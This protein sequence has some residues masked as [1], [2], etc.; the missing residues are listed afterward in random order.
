MEIK[1]QIF[2]DGV[3]QRHRSLKALQPDYV[4][5]DERTLADGL[6]FA[7]VYAKQLRYFNL[8][9]QADGDWF[10]FFAGDIQQMLDYLDHPE[11][12][13]PKDASQLS[14]FSQPH[15]ALF[16]T[17][18]KL[19][20][21]PQQQFKDLTQRY[22]D[23]YYRDVLR[24]TEKAATPD[25]VHVVFGLG[26]GE[27]THLIRQGTR[28]SA[29]PDS[30][31]V[32]Q[33]Y[34]LN[35]DIYLNQAQVASV[36]TLAVEKAYID[37]KAIH[38]K[39]NRS[40]DAF[41]NVLRWA[42]GTPNQGDALPNY[43]AGEPDDIP[44]Y[45]AHINTLYLDNVKDLSLEEIETEPR[46]YILNQLCFASIENFQ[47]CLH[48]HNREISVD[49]E[50]VPPTDS[51]WEQVYALIEKAYR[52]KIT[53][54]RRLVLSA[55]HRNPQYTSPDVAFEAML[56]LALGYPDPGDSLPPLPDGSPVT[57]NT[58]NTLF[59]VFNPPDPA[60]SVVQNASQYVQEQLYMSVDDFQTIME[61]KQQLATD[62]GTPDYWT[63]QG[64]DN[65]YRL[66]EKAQSKLRG[67]TYPPIGRMEIQAISAAGIANAE[68]GEIASLKRFNTFSPNLPDPDLP[69]TVPQPI[70]LAITSPV[71]LL[72]EG[73]RDVT[74]SLTFKGETFN[75]DLLSKLVEGRD[76]PFELA[77]S[78]EKEWLSITGD[79]LTVQVGEF[80][81]EEPLREF[82]R[83]ALQPFYSAPE[84]LLDDLSNISGEPPYFHFQDASV[85][86]L[87]EMREADRT[88]KLT[89]VGQ[90]APTDRIA[91]Y[92]SLVLGTYIDVDNAVLDEERQL[93][94]TRNPQFDAADE[95]K[96][97]MWANGL[98]Y[99]IS[100][101]VNSQTV[102]VRYWG[103]LPADGTNTV[104]KYDQI[105]LTT[106]VYLAAMDMVSVTIA[107]QENVEFSSGDVGSYLVWDTGGVYKI[108]GL[109]SSQEVRVE[110]VGHLSPNLVQAA[111][112]RHYSATGIVLNSLKFSFSVAATQ[113]AIAS[114][115]PD[116]SIITFDM[117]YPMVKITLK[118][119]EPGEENGN[120][121]SHYQ[122]LQDLCIEKVNLQVSVKDV[123]KLQPQAVKAT[124][125]DRS[126]DPNHFSQP[127]APGSIQ[128]L[129]ERDP[130]VQTIVQPYS[131]FKGR[132]QETSQ[133]FYTRV[134][135]RLRHKQ[136]ALTTWDYE[137]LVLENFPQIYKVKC[138]SQADQTNVPGAAQVIV[139]VIPDI[140]NTAPFFP[141]EPKAPLYL[142]KEI[143]TYL[144]TRTSPFVKEFKNCGA[145]KRKKLW[146]IMLELI[147][148]KPMKKRPLRFEPRVKKRP[149]PF[150]TLSSLP[151]SE[152]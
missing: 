63:A 51:E 81:L 107:N 138:L 91:K 130:V 8:S 110:Q 85:Y 146:T 20:Q 143:E 55:E 42:V 150:F 34:A 56:Q 123:Q 57:L 68:P 104:K 31:G 83:E 121:A 151:K 122:S 28:L 72:S 140:S 11:G 62:F 115:P 94:S 7:Q 128:A 152:V 133:A 99:Q 27:A 89:R 144:Q 105:A 15:L 70:G 106:P 40:S 58:L 49:R 134:S 2:R 97:I 137:R 18:L 47:Y 111:P 14:Q 44:Y 119:P 16:L 39:G 78:S 126:N 102:A 29:G 53:R 86:Q 113:D 9:N 147:A 36:K 141:L 54:D 38:L 93:I 125:V 35:E 148:H 67:F 12:F 98:I 145:R 139:V 21:Y 50:T 41:E 142:L 1:A 17:F 5:V 46:N 66:V 120:I 103:Y 24:L 136:R 73:T 30:Q 116:D 149:T 109:A 132:R 84:G 25:Q 88:I 117:T 26:A 43:P 23:F 92:Q 124:F 69:A 48:V 61:V 135:E 95:N 129:V 10:S 100:G 131:S 6:N 37:L 108:I 75:R 90:I 4:A 101:Y 19:F 52:K 82:A 79:E 77:I 13:A 22:L 65:V 76:V 87:N 74:V 59:E 112:I 114:P 64:W 71:L 32:D 96:F 80:V 127:L 33:Q 60:A 118:N 45:M 3:S